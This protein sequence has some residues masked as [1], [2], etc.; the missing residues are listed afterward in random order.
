[1]KLIVGLGNPG[2]RYETSRHNVGF[3][4]ADL[5]ADE[6]QVNFKRSKHEALVGETI[7]QGNKLLIAKPLTFMNLSGRAVASLINW[8]KISTEDVIIVYDDMDLEMGRL[9]IRKRGSGGGQKG[10]VSIIQA[11][12][13]EDILRVRVGIG[14]PPVEGQGAEYVLGSFSREQ[15]SIMEDILPIAGECAL[16]L[17]W[18]H[19]D[20]VMNEYNR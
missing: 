11:L 17:T 4:V 1:M 8:Y 10:M 20:H 15:W 13:T 2:L 3:I 6:L 16:R 7:Y 12:G 9:R 18:D 14:R 19:L 5:I